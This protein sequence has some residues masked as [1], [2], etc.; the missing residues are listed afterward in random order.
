L[1]LTDDL[2]PCGF[3][4]PRCHVQGSPFRGFCLPTEPHRVSPAVALVPFETPTCGLTRASE[5]PVDF[6]ALLPAESAVPRRGG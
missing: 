5:R 3:V 4:S 2:R 6:R 1:R